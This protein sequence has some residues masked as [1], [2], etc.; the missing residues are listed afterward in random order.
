MNPRKIRLL[1]G[2]FLLIVALTLHLAT[3]KW[4]TENNLSAPPLIVLRNNVTVN[5]EYATKERIAREQFTKAMKD[6]DELGG[7]DGP[8]MLRKLQDPVT[9]AAHSSLIDKIR[10]WR[11]IMEEASPHAYG[12]LGLYARGSRDSALIVGVVTAA[13]F[14]VGGLFMSVWAF[15]QQSQPIRSARLRTPPGTTNRTGSQ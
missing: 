5:E 1:A 4:G 9:R 13:I 3:C 14:L 10:Y 8:G 2:A 12:K 15:S 11:T 6:S 7:T